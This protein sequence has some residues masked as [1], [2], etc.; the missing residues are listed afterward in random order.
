MIIRTIWL[1]PVIGGHSLGSIP[2]G[3]LKGGIVFLLKGFGVEAGL[4]LISLWELCGCFH[5][6]AR[7]FVGFRFPYDKSPTIWGLCF[8]PSIFSTPT[9]WSLH[10]SF[11]YSGIHLKHTSSNDIA[12]SLG[13]YTA[14]S[15]AIAVGRC[16]IPGI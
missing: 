4:E 14:W 7:L 2:E 10:S 3:V 8:S 1:L 16:H 6:L 15:W 9:Y 11:G 12:N 5:T 13:L